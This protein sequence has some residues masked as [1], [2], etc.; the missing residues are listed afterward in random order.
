M[1]YYLAAGR[2][3]KVNSKEN[4]HTYSSTAGEKGE[5][6]DVVESKRQLL[7]ELFC[8]ILNVTRAGGWKRRLAILIND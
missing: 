4:M 6:F 1:L 8:T 3:A 7:V 5:S 2:L